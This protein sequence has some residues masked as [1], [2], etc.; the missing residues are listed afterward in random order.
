[1]NQHTKSAKE[2]LDRRYS[3]D[4]QGGYL[5]HQPI[6][7]LRTE[8][9]EPNAILRFARTYRLLELLQTLEFDSVLDVGGGEGYLAALVRDLGRA[10]TVHSS[11]LSVEACQRAGEIFDIQGLAADTTRLPFADNSYDL[12]ICSEVLEH[13]SRPVLAIGEL[14]RVAR[15]FVVITTAEFCPAGETE[16]ALRSWTLDRSYPHA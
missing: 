7:G 2:W 16:R 14:A 12:V 15:K 6:C 1:M 4:S 13:L 5:A 8:R 11:D 9:A 3:R 10:K